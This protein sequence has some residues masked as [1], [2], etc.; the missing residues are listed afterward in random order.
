M[1]QILFLLPYPIGCAPSQRF[2]V[3]QLL[4]LLED[5]AAYATPTEM[6]A[7][8]LAPFMDKKVWT[9]LYQGGTTMQKA[10][11]ILRSFARRWALMLGGVRRYDYVFIHR[12]AAPLGPPVFEW[13]LRFIWRKRFI[14]DFDDAL[15]I[16]NT[17][18]ENKIAAALKAHWKTRCLCK[19]SYKV[20][21][22]NAYLCR[23][24]QE[25]GAQRVILLP[26]VV[27][28][29]HRYNQVKKHHTGKPVIGWTGSHS[30]LKYLDE[31]M[32]V[33]AALQ[34]EI[35]FTFLVI[36]DKQPN[37]PLKDWQFIRW[38]P[39]TEIEDLL[40]ID[41]GIMP[42]TEDLWSAGKCGF[43]LIQYLSLGIPAVASPVGV[44]KDIVQEGATGFL[45]PTPAAWHK[46]LQQL[47][48]SPDLRST[49][50]QKGRSEVM[51]QYSVQSQKLIFQQLFV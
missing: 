9:V 33:L 26:T 6:P 45:C 15:W 27:D 16:A 21:A 5:A 47:I 37:L 40:R 29:Q 18:A 17:S 8:Q 23:Y 10:M 11:G 24:A 48:Q 36:A 20:T 38:N 32:P 51:A 35:P 4:P 43:K 39:A 13:M 44:N 34:E 12:E 22:G 28:T 41:I 31:L 7:Y 2:R 49:M 1:P 19:W 14:F 25:S 42:L 3:E 46:A 30:T 50:G